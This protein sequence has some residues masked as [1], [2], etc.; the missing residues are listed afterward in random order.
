MQIWKFNVL[1][2]KPKFWGNLCHFL[3]CLFTTNWEIMVS[4]WEQEKSENLLHSV[5]S[6]W[7]E[8][9]FVTAS[10]M[11]RQP[12]NKGKEQ[13]PNPNLIYSP[14]ISQSGSANND[15]VPHPALSKSY[16]RHL[17][18]SSGVSKQRTN[19]SHPKR[20]THFAPENTLLHFD[21]HFQYSLEST[22]WSQNYVPVVFFA[23]E[24]A[25]ISFVNN[26]FSF[27]A[28]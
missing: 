10:C 5:I 1:I 11:K 14:M 22:S 17:R 25:E 24:K 4:S 20:A 15:T 7:Y 6:D 26:L 27:H 12:S 18:T 16:T 2:T 21:P 13:S 8:E 3:F 9:R 19:R 28:L 23:E